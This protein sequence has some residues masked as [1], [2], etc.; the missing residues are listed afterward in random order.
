MIQKK[1]KEQSKELTLEMLKKYYK[2]NKE[3]DLH[4]FALS[5][6][7]AIKGLL[8]SKNLCTNEE[9]DKLVEVSRDVLIKRDFDVMSEEDKSILA[10]HIDNENVLNKF[11][12]LLGFDVKN[13]I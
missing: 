12:S 3:I 4:F 13:F 5:S 8:V 10:K 6:I 2:D 11:S 1:E 7:L 9:F